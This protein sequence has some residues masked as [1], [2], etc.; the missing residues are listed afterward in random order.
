MSVDAVEREQRRM[1]GMESV[2]SKVSDSAAIDALQ[3]E[4]A[5]ALL[6]AHRK[7]VMRMMEVLR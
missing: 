4:G 2:A 5:V 1:A 3:D 7:Q 6:R